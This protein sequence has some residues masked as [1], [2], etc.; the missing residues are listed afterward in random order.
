MPKTIDWE[1]VTRLLGTITTEADLARRAVTHGR[2]DPGV[3][4]AAWLRH[5]AAAM[6]LNEMDLFA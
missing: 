6:T 3:A 5:E 4:R 2:F 1:V